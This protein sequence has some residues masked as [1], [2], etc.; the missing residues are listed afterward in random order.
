MMS[1]H[2]TL[3]KYC[4]YVVDDPEG[5][6]VVQERFHIYITSFERVFQGVAHPINQSCGFWF[7]IVAPTRF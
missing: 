7:E 1:T 6:L 5:N 3:C 2:Y 4:M